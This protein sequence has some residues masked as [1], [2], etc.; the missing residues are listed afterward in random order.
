MCTIIQRVLLHEEVAGEL[1]VS[2]IEEQLK[3]S[4]LCF[5]M[6]DNTEGGYSQRMYVKVS[7]PLHPPFSATN[8]ISISSY[9]KLFL[10]KHYFSYKIP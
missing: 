10:I 4:L 1:I 6:V 2:L 3:I 5:S 7:F 9:I 8:L